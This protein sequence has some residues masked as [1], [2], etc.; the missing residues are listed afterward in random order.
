MNNEDKLKKE[1]EKLKIELLNKEK[2]LLLR[3]CEERYRSFVE[4]FHGIAFRGKIDWVPVFFRGAVEQV[5]GYKEEDFLAGKPRWDQIIYTED[6]PKIRESVD[7]ISS[8][9][10]YSTEREYRITTKDGHIKW[11][12][13]FIQNICDESGKPVYVQGALYDITGYK[14]A[15]EEL[16]KSQKL[17]SLGVLAGGIAHDFNN[18]LGGVFGYID[19]AKEFCNKDDAISKYLDKALNAY[20]RAK[21]MTFQLRAFAKGGKPVKKVISIGPVIKESCKLALSGS[22]IKCNF[23]IKKNLWPAEID[24]G[25]VHQ[26]LNNIMLNARQAMPGGG[27]VEVKAKNVRLKG[28]EIASLQKGEYIRI[29]ITDHGQG[30]P[31]DQLPKIFDPFYTTKE[32]GSG[33]GLAMCYSIIKNHDGHIEVESKLDIGTTFTIYLSTSKKDKTEKEGK[34]HTPEG[35]AG[36][37]ILVMDDEEIIRELAGEILK[38]AGYE[39]ELSSNGEEAV[40]SYRNALVSGKKYDAIILDLTIAGGKGGKEIVEKLLEMDPAVKA[41]VSSG[42]SDDSVLADPRRYGFKAFVEKPY[43]AQE[44][45]EIT[46]KVLA[47]NKPRNFG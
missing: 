16:Q 3:D 13:E 34:K 25:Q 5:T 28:E 37:R 20:Q 26:V 14:K 35:K 22:N 40:Q 15:Q 36:G 44:L 12:R 42:Y 46:G 9:P 33:L 24:E 18:L 39:V 27:P 19:L 8:V 38:N 32:G 23:S 1:L 11:V 4:N 17:E 21:D 7:N 45:R 30:I 31:D 6:W 10:N 2:Q 47:D 29:Q 41:I 43:R